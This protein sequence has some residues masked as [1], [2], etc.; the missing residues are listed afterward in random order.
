MDTYN[1]KKL[2]R[3]SCVRRLLSSDLEPV[4]DKPLSSN[5]DVICPNVIFSGFGNGTS[6]LS[7]SLK[8]KDKCF[9]IEENR[10]R[11][12]S[13][14]SHIDDNDMVSITAL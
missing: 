8:L 3:S 10:N 2:L 1:E 6:S 14:H 11:S 9:I 5:S 7:I 12:F 4:V 13:D